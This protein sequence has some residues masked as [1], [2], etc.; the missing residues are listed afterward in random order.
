MSTQV[1]PTLAGLEVEIKRTELWGG[2]TI[3][4]SVSGK[5]TG[6]QN[7]SYPRYLWELSAS[8]LPSSSALT[9]APHSADFQSLLGFFNS[10]G[11]RFDTFLFTDP[12]DY[13]VTGQTIDVGD[14]TTTAFQ[15]IR[16]FGG[17]IEPVYAPHTVSSVYMNS[18]SQ[19]SS[20]WSVASWGSTAPGVLTFTSA[21]ASSQTITADFSYYWP[22][23]FDDDSMTYTRFLQ[24]LYD[25]KSIKFSSEK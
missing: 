5:R 8:V 17:F 3:Q 7:W 15:L 11:G 18:V 10:R 22:V 20:L 16:T 14:T 2:T 13:S 23:R 24:Y 9:N 6:I 19:G 21:P 25:N 12:D 1:F 4:E